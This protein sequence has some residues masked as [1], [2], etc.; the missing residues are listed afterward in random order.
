[1]I[2]NAVEQARGL[3]D[4]AVDRFAT[5]AEW[6]VLLAEPT[7]DEV[8]TALKQR[9]EGLRPNSQAIVAITAQAFV[10]DGTPV[11][12]FADYRPND[13]QGTGLPL[14][15]LL[16][17]IDGAPPLQKVVLL[18][19]LHPRPG[20]ED[21][22]PASAELLLKDLA[23]PKSTAVF[24]A[25]ADGVTKGVDEVEFG[26]LVV[27][28]LKGAADGDRDLVITAAEWKEYLI[29]GKGPARARAWPE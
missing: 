16:A 13:A 6:G 28:G 8:V 26:P 4:A 14:A 12:A 2:E 27:Q 17:L 11:L 3:R 21:A 18:D 7:R 9:L 25:P 15:E 1:V 5:P 23:R 24:V 29:K 20:L 19:V 22:A 10:L